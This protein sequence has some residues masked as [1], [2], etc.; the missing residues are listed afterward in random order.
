MWS[1]RITFSCGKQKT[2]LQRLKQI[3][4]DFSHITNC[5]RGRWWFLNQYQLPDVR[6]VSPTLSVFSH[7]MSLYDRSVTAT[8]PGNNYKFRVGG[9]GGEGDASLTCSYLLRKKVFCQ[10]PPEQ[11][12]THISLLPAAK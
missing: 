5:I 12:I 11:T 9:E 2:H 6:T 3:R 10:E 7:C 8:T 1:V 4:A